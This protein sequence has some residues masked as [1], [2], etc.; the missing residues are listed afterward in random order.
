M[1]EQMKMKKA[2]YH[3]WTFVT[4]K[5]IS[6]FGAQ[7]YA[8]AIS[9]Y[10]LQLTGSATNF[11]VNLICNILPRTLLSPIAGYMTDNYSRKKIVIISQIVTTVAIGCLLL[12]N[13]TTGLS[14]LAIYATTC[15]LSITSTFSSLAFSSSISRLVD[16]DRLQRAMSLNQMSVSIAAIGS[17]AVGGLMYG[18]VSMSTFLI[19][20]MVASAIAVTLESTM[21]F[22]LF[23][24]GEKQES[25][26]KKESMIQSMKAGFSYMKGQ[27]VVMAMIWLSLMINFLFG[28]FEVGYSFILI[29][30]FNMNSEH[31]G[32]TEG[33][34]AVGML[35]L[36]I[37]LSAREEVRY[38]FLVSKRSLLSIGGAMT[39]FT[40]PLFIPF[41]YYILFAYYLILMFIFGG[42]IIVTN[43]P[44]QVML[45]KTIDDEYK[46]RIFSIIETMAMALMPIGTLLFGVLYDIFPAQWV[47][48]TSAILSIIAVLILARPSIVRKAHPELEKSYYKKVEYHV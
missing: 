39:L 41:S 3:L 47:L 20:Y 38:P 4:S 13:L 24:K 34:F 33:M 35:V 42:L 10:I 32:L 21:D 44:V 7:V 26:E 37:Y 30:K 15:I 22:N 12:V 18:V 48:L 11:A 8:F 36:S 31:F 6:A 40:V 1:D 5:L 23:E 28:G 16:A 17:P 45:Q 29:E 43:T 25:T 19:I 14:L 9:L 2:T 27:P 46:G